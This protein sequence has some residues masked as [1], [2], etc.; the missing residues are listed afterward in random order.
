MSSFL[1]DKT[2]LLPY[3]FSDPSATAIDEALAMVDD[4]TRIHVLHVLVPLSAVSIEPGVIIDVGGDNSRREAARNTMEER[5]SDKSRDIEFSARLGD[6]GTEIVAY[7]NDI[8]ADMII[9]P[10]H[11]RTG[12]NRLLLGSVAERVLRL[13]DCPVLVLRHVKKK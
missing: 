6:P 12:L 8:Q 7:A 13:A 11:G 3:D 2:V 10:S 4:S 5:L 9:M 1:F